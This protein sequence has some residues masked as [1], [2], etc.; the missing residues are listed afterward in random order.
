M[1]KNLPSGNKFAALLWGL[2]EATAFFIVPDVLLSYIALKQPKKALIAS[3]FV[4][5]GALL[6]GVILY[7]WA[8]VNNAVALNFL[9]AVP[10]ISRPLIDRANALMSHN[11]LYGML[12]GS[13]S[14]VPYKIF[15]VQAAT[16]HIPLILFI[17]YSIPARLLR[18][19][20]VIGVVWLLRGSLLKRIEQRTMLNL[21]VG[22]WGIFYLCYFL[23]MG[24]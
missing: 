15:C 21:F 14:G 17:A 4:L 23:A 20:L 10:G 5:I 24:W 9:D 1:K 13:F 11:I 19:L 22:F 3:L 7:Q 12:A 16:L 18:F 8:S 6:G 2:A